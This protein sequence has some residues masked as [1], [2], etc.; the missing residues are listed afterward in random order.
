MVEEDDASSSSTPSSFSSSSALSVKR[1]ALHGHP[2]AVGTLEGGFS[3]GGSKRFKLDFGASGAAVAAGGF[4]NA[5]G[6]NDNDDENIHAAFVASA[7]KEAQADDLLGGD[8]E[9]PTQRETNA[10]MAAKHWVKQLETKA[11][12]YMSA[13]TAAAAARHAGS[14]NSMTGGSDS[15]S[16]SSSSKQNNRGNGNSGGSSGS[17]G[18]YLSAEAAQ[19]TADAR[20]VSELLPNLLKGVMPKLRPVQPAEIDAE[21][22]INSLRRILES[23]LSCEY[24]GSP[25]VE[26][27]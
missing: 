21:A 3:P 20:L 13:R 2:T 16:S 23:D 25:E 4:A 10:Q 1:P 18:G 17:G 6:S 26:C 27:K 11:E 7:V 5:R 19:A 15:S 12:L 8:G 14:L 22:L 9:G 24:L